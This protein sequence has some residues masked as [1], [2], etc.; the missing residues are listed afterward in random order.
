MSCC[1]HVSVSHV[2]LAIWPVWAVDLDLLV[3]TCLCV[4]RERRDSLGLVNVGGLVSYFCGGRVDFV[5]LFWCLFS[6]PG[7]GAISTHSLESD[8]LPSVIK[9]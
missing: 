2:G 6:R 9:T 8:D 7:S 3:C 5:T 4:T 1:L